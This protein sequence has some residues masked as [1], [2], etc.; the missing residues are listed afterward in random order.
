[1]AI[2]DSVVLA[3]ELSRAESC[4]EAFKA[5]RRRRFERCQFIVDRSRYICESQL[6][7]RPPVNQAE[8]TRQMFEV[9]AAPI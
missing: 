2:E 4:E 9:I 8:E 5:Y 7:L 6:G 3:E 1:M